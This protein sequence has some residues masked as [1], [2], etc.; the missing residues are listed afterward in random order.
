MGDTDHGCD[1]FSDYDA[2]FDNNGYDARFD[3]THAGLNYYDAGFDSDDVGSDHDRYDDLSTF[4]HEY[5]FHDHN[6][7]NNVDHFYD[8]SSSHDHDFALGQSGAGSPGRSGGWNR[9]LGRV[10]SGEW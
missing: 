10:D 6:T 5:D 7:I 3:D 2:G 9:V 1:G 8:A 4:Q